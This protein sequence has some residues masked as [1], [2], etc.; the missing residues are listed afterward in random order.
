MRISKDAMW[1]A[2]Q[3]GRIRP[4]EQEVI[5]NLRNV[6]YA[7]VPLSITILATSC[8]RKWCHTMAPNLTRGMNHFKLVYGNVN[9]FPIEEGY[10]NHSWVIKDGFVYDTTDGIRWDQ[11]SYYSLFCPEEVEVYTEDTIDSYDVYQKILGEEKGVPLLNQSLLIQYYEAVESERKGFNY[12]RFCE[13]VE[14]WR[15]NNPG[16]TIFTDDDIKR[17]RKILEDMK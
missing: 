7:G 1:D 6:Y 15:M 16:Y 2:I 11:D 14:L 3:D 17:Y 9:Y 4:F 8:C 12:D 5:E 10:P 13:E